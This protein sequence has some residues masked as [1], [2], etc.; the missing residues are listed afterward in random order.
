M[1]CALSHLNPRSRLDEAL[2]QVECRDE[3][4][5]CLS[6]LLH[7][8]NQEESEPIF[9]IGE[10]DA[11]YTSW[12]ACDSMGDALKVPQKTPRPVVPKTKRV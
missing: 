7:Y 12:V 8:L 3:I 2:V 11:F 1:Y 9:L 6:S 4:D 10:R 5:V